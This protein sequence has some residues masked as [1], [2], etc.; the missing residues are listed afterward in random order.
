MAA[1]YNYDPNSHI[2]YSMM[3]NGTIDPYTDVIVY[4]GGDLSND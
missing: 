3:R 4:D 1:N 2:F